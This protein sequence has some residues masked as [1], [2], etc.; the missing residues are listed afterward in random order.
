MNSAPR[1]S[2]WRALVGAA[3]VCLG[4]G[5]CESG[6]H[7]VERTLNAPPTIEVSS[8]SRRIVQGETVTLSMLNR[9]TIGRDAFVEWESTGGMLTA[10][11]NGRI[12]RARFD[13]PGTY[14]VTAVLIVDGEEVDRDS[15]TVEVVALTTPPPVQ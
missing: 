13:E 2:G 8:S 4:L 6:P 5:A 7:A 3:A 12:V 15:A 14:T 9:N 11:E 10:E 1:R